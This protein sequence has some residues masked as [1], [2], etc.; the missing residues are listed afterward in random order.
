MIIRVYMAR[1]KSI[2]FK[3]FNCANASDL[4]SSFFTLPSNIFLNNLFLLKNIHFGL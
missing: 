1:V 4:I 3:K 2:N